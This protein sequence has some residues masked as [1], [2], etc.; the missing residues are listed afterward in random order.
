[1]HTYIHTYIHAN[2]LIHRFH[3]NSD[4]T[5]IS[6]RFHNDFTSISHRFHND[7]TTISQRLHIG[8]TTI[9]QR[10]HIGFTTISPL[11]H[12]FTARSA[13]NLL[14]SSISHRTHIHLTPISHLYHAER[15]DFY[16]K[17]HFTP[18][19]HSSHHQF[20]TISY[21]YRAARGEFFKSL[22]CT[23]LTFIPPQIHNDFITLP[24]RAR[25]FFKNLYHAPNSHSSHHKF[26]TISYL[27]GAERGDFFKSLPR[28]AQ[29]FVLNSISH[30]THIHPTTISQRFHISTARS[31]A[32]FLNPSISRDTQRRNQRDLFSY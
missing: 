32:N 26:T 13:A 31:A 8:F 20:T 1:M 6:H 27:Y 30:R 19:S 24:H 29:R 18:N 23:E 14:N 28:G 17:F 12:I 11:F 25:R 22:P 15:G 4:F 3:M 7:L 9:S 16:L 10:I 21:L 2:L 5:T